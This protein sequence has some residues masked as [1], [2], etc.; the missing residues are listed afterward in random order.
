[1]S[2]KYSPA[3]NQAFA[4]HPTIPGSASPA[5]DLLLV[6]L[7]DPF[8]GV[9][10]ST[11]IVHT[12]VPATDGSLTHQWMLESVLELNPPRFFQSW[13][14]RGSFT[15]DLSVSA[16]ALPV[17]GTW[18]GTV[19]T[20]SGAGNC[21]VIVMRDADQKVQF[22]LQSN[23]C[24]APEKA[25]PPPAEQRFL[26]ADIAFETNGKS[27]LSAGAVAV[28]SNSSWSHLIAGSSVPT[29]GL[30][31]DGKWRHNLSQA[32]GDSTVPGT[33]TFAVMTPEAYQ[34]LCTTAGWAPYV[35]D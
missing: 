12:T 5:P 28:I 19:T 16:T 33:W 22:S 29:L 15:L 30:A 24:H 25:M 7:Q 14:T 32:D 31:F 4:T 21:R 23:A 35:L 18:G 17:T 11:N 10:D 13:A 8:S 26:N 27:G 6:C 9:G 2:A 1:M 20:L 34:A 3:V